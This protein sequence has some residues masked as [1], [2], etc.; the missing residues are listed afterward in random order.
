MQPLELFQYVAYRICENG[1]R[2]VLFCLS[3]VRFAP[4]SDKN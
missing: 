1:L 3:F 2:A 4:N